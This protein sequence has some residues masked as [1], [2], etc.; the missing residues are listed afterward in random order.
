VEFERTFGMLFGFESIRLAMMADRIASSVQTREAATERLP[1][2]LAIPSVRIPELT[3]KV[4]IEPIAMRIPEECF[5]LRCFRVSNYVW[6]RNLVKGWGGD[7][8]GV[9]ATPGADYHVRDR[10]ESQL[11]LNIATLI[12]ARI[13]A[14]RP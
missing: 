11:G 5:Y 9:V 14:D 10:I 12:D 7:L 8:D 4:K 3:E 6:V 2:R 13:D 1:Q